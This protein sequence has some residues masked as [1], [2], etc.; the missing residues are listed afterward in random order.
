MVNC[1]ELRYFSEV[2]ISLHTLEQP[3]GPLMT[4]LVVQEIQLS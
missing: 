2:Q 3:L 1:L 4:Y